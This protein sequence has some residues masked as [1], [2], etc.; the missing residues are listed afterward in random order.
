MTLFNRLIIALVCALFHFHSN[1]QNEARINECN[2]IVLA[3]QKF[4]SYV[5]TINTSLGNLINYTYVTKDSLLS[6]QLAFVEY[7]EGSMH[8]DS[9]E[10]MADFFRTTID[11]SVIR[12]KGNKKYESEIHQF[13][14]PGWFWKTTYGKNKFM[15]TKAFMAGK[16]FYSMQVT[17]DIKYDQDKWTF[18]FFDS[19]QF[20]DLKLVK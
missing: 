11:E 5:D 16:R 18:P 20:I 15:K 2:C 17:G 7:P 9:T 4:R 13:G 1:A 14:Y 8:S 12:L 6:Y 10:L 19:F 3:P